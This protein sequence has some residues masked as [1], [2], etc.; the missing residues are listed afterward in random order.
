MTNIL[1][2]FYIGMTTL[3]LVNIFIALLTSTF[4]RVHD[5]SKAY[6]VLQRAIEIINREN[7]SVFRRKRP[8]H[9][10]ELQKDYVDNKYSVTSELPS[11]LSETMEPVKDT[12]R[13]IREEIVS[14][15]EKLES[16]ENEIVIPFFLSVFFQTK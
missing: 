9:L 4:T 12:M 16:L 8:E 7:H 6:F 3:L 14:L 13:D 1:V 5:S 15:Y 11:S 2:G 10:R